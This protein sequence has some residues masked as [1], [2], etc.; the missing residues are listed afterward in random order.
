MNAKIKEIIKLFFRLGCT[1]FG[2]PVAHIAMMDEEF[3]EKRKWLKREEF[4]DLM[5]ATNMIPGPNSTEMTMH[6]GMERAGVKGMIAA[7]TS[8]IFPAALMT[9]VLA[10][11]YVEFG[12]LPDFEK[13]M[14]GIQPVVIVIILGA[15]L[16]LYKKAVKTRPLLYIS[17][18]AAL[19]VLLGVGEI[20]TLLIGAVL[21]LGLYLFFTREKS[22]NTGSDLKKNLLPFLPAFAGTGA[23]G[24]GLYTFS[25]AG[26]FWVFFKVGAVLFGSGYVLFAYLEGAL[27]D[28][29]QWLTKDQLMDAIA[30]GQF[31]P[32]PVLTTATFIGFQ[33]GGWMG[34]LLATLGI[35]IP[36]FAYV[37]ILNPLVPKMRS[38]KIF[39]AILDA[40]NV[41]ALGLMAAVLLTL[42]AHS[43]VTPQAF[44]IAGL[45]FYLSYFKKV[46]APWLVLMGGFL[47]WFLY[48]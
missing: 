7:G 17:L 28:D 12:H 25:Y 3:V 26:L 42:A 35:F 30:I 29:L 5:G 15:L 8:F 10:W 48:P 11:I 1:A 47:G 38:S 4:L 37:A 27:I 32:G 22:D 34:A 33:I 44:L 6:L 43:M 19:L 31:T 9:A 18:F 2:G 45:A 39:G 13:L 20:T 41:A 23:I 46:S 16:K 24:G 14:M 21:G 36:S 40:V